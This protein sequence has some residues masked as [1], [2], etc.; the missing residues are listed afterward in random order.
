M[1]TRLGM[2]SSSAAAVA[3]AWAARGAVKAELAQAVEAGFSAAEAKATVA[4]YLAAAAA[5]SSAPAGR[6]IKALPTP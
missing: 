5:A 2:L 3:A 1:L 4:L 6:Q